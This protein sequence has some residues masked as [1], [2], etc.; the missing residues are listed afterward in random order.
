MKE[1]LHVYYSKNRKLIR[2]RGATSHHIAAW[3]GYVDIFKNLL[4]NCQ[5]DICSRTNKGLNVLHYAAEFGHVE[6]VRLP[7]TCAFT[8][9]KSRLRRQALFWPM[10]MILLLDPR[11]N[12]ELMQLILDNRR[13]DIN[14][15]DS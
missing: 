1:D 5:V 3:K 4:A 2:T 7:S 14:S 8:L 12:D 9:A 6:I 11:A 15:T 10:S 13:N